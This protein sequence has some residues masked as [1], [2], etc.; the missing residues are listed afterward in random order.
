MA[1]TF[2]GK[3][4]DLCQEKLSEECRGC[5]EGPGRRFG[6]NCP[7]ADCCREKYHANC[8]TCQEAMSCTKR[9]QKDQMQ[10]IRIAEAAAKDEKEIQ[11]RE[12]AK[13]LGKWLWLL[14]WLLIPNIIAGIMSNESL[15]PISP[16]MY[17]IGTILGIVVEIIYC[18]VL[19]MLRHVEKKYGRAAICTIVGVVLAAIGLVLMEE[20]LVFAVLFMFAT[21]AVSLAGSYF[22]YYGHAAVLE[23]FDVEFSEKWEKLWKWQ[24]IC[25]CGAVAGVC[26]LFLWILGVL[27]VL[28]SAIGIA[29]VSIV[30]MVYLYRMA[31]MFREYT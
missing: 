21:V 11:K 4:C 6:G 29:V 9:Q 31:V 5:K 23:D 27:L 20:L 13:V 26:L 1:E 12:K 28:A 18:I 10:Q 17:Y 8:D 25:L 30:Q 3:D 24:I 22:L 14:F 7:I 16:T 2:C 15:K 19:F